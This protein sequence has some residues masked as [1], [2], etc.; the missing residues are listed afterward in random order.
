MLPAR[1]SVRCRVWL[2]YLL[3]RRHRHGVA[4]RVIGS[5]HPLQLLLVCAPRDLEIRKHVLRAVGEQGRGT[6][7]HAPLRAGRGPRP[8]PSR[9]QCAQRSYLQA[10]QGFEGKGAR[11]ERP[12]DPGLRMHTVRVSDRCVLEEFHMKQG[13]RKWEDGG[14]GSPVRRLTGNQ[15]DA[16]LDRVRVQL[17]LPAPQVQM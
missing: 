5:L 6:Q 10:P 11:R 1:A 4:E 17:V 15:I 16:C 12:W 13:E 9:A 14:S 3:V 2:C 7:L 8:R